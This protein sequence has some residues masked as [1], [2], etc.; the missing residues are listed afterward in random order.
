MIN[1]KELSPEQLQRIVEAEQTSSPL[2]L[3]IVL[4]V[5]DSNFVR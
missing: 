1:G 3:K 5:S 2:F 4:S